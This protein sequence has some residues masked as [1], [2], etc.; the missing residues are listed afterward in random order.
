MGLLCKY[1][2]IMRNEEN[3]GDK[4]LMATFLR[5]GFGYSQ[6]YIAKELG[7][8]RQTLTKKEK[9]KLEYNKKEMVILQKIYSQHQPGIT[10]EDIFFK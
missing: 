10:I 4:V 6:E 7:I 2:N 3:G 1:S 9:G 5:R 8:C